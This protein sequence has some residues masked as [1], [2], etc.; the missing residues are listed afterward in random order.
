MLNSHKFR[1][2]VAMDRLVDLDYQAHGLNQVLF[3]VD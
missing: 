2:C 1:V 3:D